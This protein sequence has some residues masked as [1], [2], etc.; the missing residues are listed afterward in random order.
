MSTFNIRP[1]TISHGDD[2]LF[3][4][5]WDSQLPWL[6]EN[7]GA[8]QWGTQSIR[9]A[10]PEAGDRVRGWLKH[11]EA[12]TPWGPEWCRAFVAEAQPLSKT[13]HPGAQKNGQPSDPVH[14]AAISLESKAAPYTASILPGQDESDPF[15]YVIYLMSNRSAGE[16]SKGAGSALIQYAKQVAAAHGIKRLCLDCYRGND[17]KLVKLVCSCLEL[18][19]IADYTI[20]IMRSRG[21]DCLA[22]SLLEIK[23]GLGVCWK[24]GFDH[25]GLGSHPMLR[26]TNCDTI[27]RCHTPTEHY[28]CD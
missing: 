3:L 1:A 2:E 25:D 27:L 21:F 10:R 4:D 12:G 14:V 19:F 17:R 8:D 22:T 16:L 6:A 9:E 20:G 13:D 26:Y 5:L 18:A 24:C 15:V 23:S 7:G 11:S 28:S